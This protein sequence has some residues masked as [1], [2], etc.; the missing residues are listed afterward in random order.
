[1]DDVK[2]ELV[3]LMESLIKRMRLDLMSP[4]DEA[5]DVEPAYQEGLAHPTTETSYEWIAHPKTLRLTTR[6]RLPLNPDGTRERS[7]GRISKSCNMPSIIYSKSQTVEF[8]AERI[9]QEALIALFHKLHPE[10]SG[11]NL[12]L[13]NICATNMALVATDHNKD[14]PGRDIGRM[15]KTQESRLKEWQVEDVDDIATTTPFGGG[16]DGGGGD[17]GDS[18][19][20]EQRTLESEN[21]NNIIIIKKKGVEKEPTEHTEPTAK[22]PPPPPPP[23]QADWIN[24]SLNGRNTSY[25]QG[26]GCCLDDDD[27]K[28][29]WWDSDE[30]NG[31]EKGEICR[32]CGARMPSFAM[33]A[34]E[35]FHNLTD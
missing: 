28:G 15:F 17:G 25:E 35:R 6:P 12:S 3:S 9:T 34:H 19:E 27:D 24:G 33:E 23:P 26:G 14:G 16:G 21:N 8:L 29:W 4:I 18:S 10:Q 30:N 22:G 7:F 13:I 5:D 32:V 11:W 1:M 20:S 2:K 31:L